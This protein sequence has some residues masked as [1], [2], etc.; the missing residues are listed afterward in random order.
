MLPFCPRLSLKKSIAEMTTVGRCSGEPILTG[1][2]FLARIFTSG[3]TSKMVIVS[4]R[5]E[6]ANP[7]VL[8]N[9]VKHKLESLTGISDIAVRSNQRLITAEKKAG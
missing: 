3:T 2:I 1:R 7:D 4:L 9:F 6:S 5:Y 8:K